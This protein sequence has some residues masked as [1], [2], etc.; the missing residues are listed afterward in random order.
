MDAKTR[1]AWGMRLTRLMLSAKLTPEKLAEKIGVARSTA[2]SWRSG[3]RI[4]RRDIQER[5][6]HE[7]GCSV[8]QLNGWG[9]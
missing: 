7:L 5:L 8:S 2:Y 9:K 1:D 4:P 6:A 3:S